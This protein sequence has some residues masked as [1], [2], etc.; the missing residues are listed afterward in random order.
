[1]YMKFIIITTMFSQFYV[2]AGIVLTCRKHFHNCSKAL[3][4]YL[5]LLKDNLISGCSEGSFWG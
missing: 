1:M 5:Q 4:N 3:S 2:R